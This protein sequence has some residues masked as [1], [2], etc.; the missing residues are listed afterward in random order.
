M[1]ALESISLFCEKYLL[2]LI[3]VTHCYNPIY[4][5]CR[6]GERLKFKPCLSLYWTQLREATGTRTTV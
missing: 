2:K 4:S 5:G 6:M 1:I 3:V